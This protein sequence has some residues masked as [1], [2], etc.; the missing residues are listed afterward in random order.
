MQ[1]KISYSGKTNFAYIQKKTD[2]ISAYKIV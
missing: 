2:L 1:N